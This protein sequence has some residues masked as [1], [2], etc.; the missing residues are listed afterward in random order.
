MFRNFALLAVTLITLHAQALIQVGENVPNKCWKTVE[1]T[2]FCLDDAKD[3]VRVLLYNTGWCGDCNAEFTKLVPRVKELSNQPVTFVSLSAAGWTRPAPPDLQFLIEWKEKHEIP[4]T[5]AA[6]PK[7]AGKLFFESPQT[8]PNVAIVD[9][10]GKLAYKSIE[11][12]LDE[13]FKE[14]KRLAQ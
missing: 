6:S 7:D 10:T 11:G 12:S 3:T 9:K 13:M 1:E 8:I 14:I 4:F 2:E 5:V